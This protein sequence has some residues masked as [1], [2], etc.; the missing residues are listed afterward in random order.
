MFLSLRRL[1]TALLHTGRD[2]GEPDYR[3]D[4]TPCVDLHQVRAERPQYDRAVIEEEREA[5]LSTAWYKDS[6]LFLVVFLFITASQQHFCLPSQ[7]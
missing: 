6:H 3:R 5:G 1:P 2:F 4:T 7:T